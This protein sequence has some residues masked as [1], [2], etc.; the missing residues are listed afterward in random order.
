MKTFPLSL[1]IILS[2]ALA[3]S[4]ATQSLGTPP[5]PVRLD[6]QY[7]SRLIAP[8]LTPDTTGLLDVVLGLLPKP[9]DMKL[10]ILA[11]D[12][13]EP[14]L[15]AI[16]S[17]L[18]H[19]GTPYNVIL[20]AK[21]QALPQLDNGAKGFY[22]GVILTIGNLGICDPGCR[23]ALPLNEW[24]RLDRYAK[25]FKVRM[26]SYYTYPE[27][28]YGLIPTSAVST[29]DASPA[30]VNLTSA[31]AGVF[32]Y[33]RPTASVKVANSYVYTATTNAAAGETTTPILRLGNAVVGVTHRKADGRELMALTMDNNPYLFH[34]AV[35][36]YGVI[37]WVTKGI[38]LGARQAY[39]TPQVDDLFLA[40][41]LFDSSKAACIPAGF[42]T[43]PTFDPAGQCP[44]LR[45]EGRDL[46]GLAAWQSNIR[47][48]PQFSK[49]RVSM[50]FNGYGATEAGGASAG[51]TLVTEAVRQKNN[52]YW[53]NHTY[54]HENLDCYKPVAN[55]GICRAAN[56]A[57]SNAEIASN[58]SLANSLGLPL[59]GASMVTPG[60]SG[61]RNPAFL[62]AAAA[63]GIK[64]LIADLSRPEGV[65]ASPNTGIWSSLQPS[66]FM[67]PR[68]PTNIFYNTTTA[69][70]QQPGS[71]PD[72]YNY[73]YGPNGLFRIG[74][75]GGPPFFD[76]TQ[77]W[78]QIADRE[79]DALLSYMLRGEMYP[80][81]FHQ[82]N[83]ALFDGTRSLFSEVIGMT[84]NKFAAISSLP[85]V[86]VNQ[87]D[88]GLMLS[89]RNAYKQSVVRATL[90]PGL[91]VEIQ[92]SG[93]ASVPLT[94]VCSQ[95]CQTYGTE[96]Q[97]LISV[98]AG[99]TRT[100][101]LLL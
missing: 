89:Q 97:S 15:A 42:T 7:P 36:H 10:L 35:F 40:N 71:Q 91:T 3:Q 92:S 43:D 8:I 72:E 28:R 49:F 4:A 73:F 95:N 41:D 82:G 12:G 69:V 62:S 66:I 39:F 50:A 20:L 21:G 27:A 96:K 13:N 93:A 101:L 26:V 88:L 68:R 17:F 30:Y 84:L 47:S 37:Q 61:L 57:E 1:S 85:V 23:S 90:T 14:G 29:S 51:D 22:Q 75:P 87:S 11:T 6:L 81:M 76:T 58:V 86:S 53:I 83:L 60:I 80:S 33:L 55:S 45:V 38:F 34:S 25:A 44:T 52:F 54:D 19:M 70:L 18:D 2:L 9:V 46:S 67:I 79:S 77:S 64:Y 24:A 94:G 48:N 98:P 63:R 100:I 99:G 16:K 74:G 65:P 32:P 59:D 56:V 78:N 5:L 31:G